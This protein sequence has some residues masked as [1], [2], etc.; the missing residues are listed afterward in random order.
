MIGGDV[1]R[2]APESLSDEYSKTEETF[3]GMPGRGGL[4]RYATWLLMII[5]VANKDTYTP[6]FKGT[7][8]PFV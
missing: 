4:Y 1:K 6:A 3:T 2:T 7:F 8:T 5:D